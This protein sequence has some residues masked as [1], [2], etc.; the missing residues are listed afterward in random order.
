L[1]ANQF[2]WDLP[3]GVSLH[4]IPGNRPEDEEDE[5]FWNEM[6]KQFE[7]HNLE[8]PQEHED[9][10]WFTRAI[11]IC[12]DMAFGRGYK[13]GADDFSWASQQLEMKGMDDG[14]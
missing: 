9:S 13:Q 10:E 4:H 5:A 7:Q 2:G 6:Y 8:I 11:E 14:S 1:P 12:R 3:P